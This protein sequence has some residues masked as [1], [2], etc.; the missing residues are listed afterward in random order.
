MSILVTG[1]MVAVIGVGTENGNKFI[2]EDFCYASTAPQKPLVLPKEDKYILFISDLGMAI[3]PDPKAEAARNALVDFLSGALGPENNR[4]ASKVVRVII[5]GN[6]LSEE[7]RDQEKELEVL[8]DDVEDEWNRKE[9]AYTVETM[10]IMDDFLMSLGA[11]VNVDVMPGPLDATSILMPQQPHHP[12]LLPKSC[13]L[14]SVTCV[15]NPYEATFDGILFVGTSG[16][17]VKSIYELSTHDEPVDIL[18]QTITWRHLAPTAPDS[19]PSYP[20]RDRDPFV[21]DEVPHVYFTGNSKS[22][23]TKLRKKDDS[24][25]RILSIPSFQSTQTCVLL[26]LKNLECEVVAFNL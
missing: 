10:E 13:R 7:S 25:C 15:S 12:C 2:V 24:T 4:K 9:R 6:C 1:V 18:D 23:N 26:N 19:V 20:F 8:E 17:V 11:T 5:A 22:F 16:Q 3:N 21:M 14:S